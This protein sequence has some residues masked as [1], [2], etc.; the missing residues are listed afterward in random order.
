[1]KVLPL[2]ISVSR[3]DTRRADE[4]AAGPPAVSPPDLH[5]SSRYELA[6]SRIRSRASSCLTD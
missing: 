2:S 4:S 6:R 3:Q 5:P 1:M